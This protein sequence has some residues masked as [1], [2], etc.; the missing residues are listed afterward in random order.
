MSK[1]E[2]IKSAISA[3]TADELARLRAWLDELAEQRFDAAIERD[4]ADGKLDNLI[5]QALADH[6]SGRTSEL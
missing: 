4:A 5:E 6:R 1:F 3:L 2:E